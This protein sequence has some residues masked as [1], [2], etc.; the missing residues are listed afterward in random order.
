M[1][2]FGIEIPKSADITVKIRLIAGR[3]KP[4]TAWEG[5]AEA[6]DTEVLDEMCRSPLVCAYLRR[7]TDLQR[8]KPDEDGMYKVPAKV[9]SYEAGQLIDEKP[10]E[11]TLCPLDTGPAE[12]ATREVTALE[13]IRTLAESLTQREE[14]L[15]VIMEQANRAHQSYE[16]AIETLSQHS[17]E[18]AQQ[19]LQTMDKVSQHAA[20]AFN[21]AAVPFAELGKSLVRAI[22][23]S[24]THSAT[25]A[26]ESTELLIEALKN[27]IIESSQVNKTSV[28]QDIKDVM[29]L[30]PLLKGLLGDV[31]PKPNKGE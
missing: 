25:S 28:A 4:F 26:K 2:F 16:R 20:A 22:D 3:G 31:D 18:T 19:A 14:H 13:V 12:G 1:S 10:A 23:D 5:C 27:R 8:L 15:Q 7:A 24:R 17:K 29:Q 6:K 30:L 21:A 9:M 11:I